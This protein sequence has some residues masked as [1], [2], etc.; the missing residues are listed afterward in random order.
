ML[1]CCAFAVV[2]FQWEGFSVVMSCD[3][4]CAIACGSESMWI[5]LPYLLWGLG[6]GSCLA[7]AKDD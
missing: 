6:R 7:D 4:V 1:T 5:I 3:G 2:T